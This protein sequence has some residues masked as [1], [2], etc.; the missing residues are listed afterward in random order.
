MHFPLA[1]LTQVIFFVH[2][3]DEACAQDKPR[4]R[5]LSRCSS[6]SSTVSSTL[7]DRNLLT[8]GIWSFSTYLS[9]SC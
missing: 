7:S 5:C 4:T 3:Q 2:K 8:P 1:L 9:P 6:L